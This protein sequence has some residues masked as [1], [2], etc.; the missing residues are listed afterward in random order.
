[1]YD[2]TETVRKIVDN[3]QLVTIDEIFIDEDE[4]EVDLFPN[5]FNCDRYYETDNQKYLLEC[6]RI[7]EDIKRLG[8]NVQFD[9]DEDNSWQ[10]I[11]IIF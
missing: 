7:L 10:F 3:Y 9:F 6:H 8:C 1:M 2:L 5:D 4:M 11:Y